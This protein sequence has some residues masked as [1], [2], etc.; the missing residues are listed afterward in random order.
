MLIT[1]NSDELSVEHSIKDE[2]LSAIR[3]PT[4]TQMLN[5][6]P[7]LAGWYRTDTAVNSTFKSHLEAVRNYNDDLNGV[8]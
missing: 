3:I 4:N 8:R 5:D 2:P 7:S 6:R 1:K